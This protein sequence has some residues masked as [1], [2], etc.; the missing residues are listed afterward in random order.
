MNARAALLR[1]D[2]M[3]MAIRYG[4]S[5]GEFAYAMDGPPKERA[6]RACRRRF[7]AL[8]RLTLALADL[9]DGAL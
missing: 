4:Q 3:E 5:C 1:H 7:A 2:V 8:E 6:N 9:P